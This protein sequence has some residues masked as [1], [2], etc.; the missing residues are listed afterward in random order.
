[1]ERVGTLINKLKEQFDQ[2]ADA[3]NLSIT[4][5]LLLAELQFNNNAESL[6]G[7]VSVMMPSIQMNHI[8]TPEIK[9]TPPSSLGWLFDTSI[10]IPT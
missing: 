6:Q 5:Q 2:Q 8:E 7:K 3:A 9:A 1:M 4:A 10:E